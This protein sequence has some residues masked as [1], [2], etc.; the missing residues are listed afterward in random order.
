MLGRTFCGL[1]VSALVAFGAQAEPAFQDRYADNDGVKIHY[2]AAG[3]GPLVVLVHGFGDT[4]HTWRPLMDALDDR[5]R[6]AAID[7]RGYNLSDKP[8][9]VEAYA[10]PQLMGDIEAVIRAENRPNAIVVAHDWG[11][12][13]AWRLAADHPQAVSRLIILSTPHPAGLTRELATNPEQQRN[14]QYARNF[15]VPGAEKSLS[16]EG[17][18]ARIKDPVQHAR[19]LEAYRRSDFTAMLNYYR[20]NYPKDEAEAAQANARSLAMPKIKVPTLIIHGVQDTSLLA[21]GH[22]SAW[23]FVEADTTI[24]MVP[25]A[26]HFVQ[27]DAPA[28][29]NRTIQDWL[30]ARPPAQ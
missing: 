6:V 30:A 12:A 7:P 20:A 15:M 25:Q 24:L 11:G 16:A 27:D 2:T 29:V 18:A 17:M 5:Y 26:G 1:L 9:G 21:A 10:Y 4:W 19:Y 28:L 14:S 22:N 23:T 3:E 13:I 8:K